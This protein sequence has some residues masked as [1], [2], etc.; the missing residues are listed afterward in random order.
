MS[1]PLKMLPMFSAMQDQLHRA[2][3]ASELAK[4]LRLPV[5][6]VKQRLETLAINGYLNR[7]SRPFAG[8]TKCRTTYTLTKQ[9]FTY[10]EYSGAGRRRLSHEDKPIQVYG[11]LRPPT[12]RGS[13]GSA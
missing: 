10:V 8:N 4:R 2:P 9:G 12:G 5:D 3:T 13:E 11:G 7:H 1:P 6:K